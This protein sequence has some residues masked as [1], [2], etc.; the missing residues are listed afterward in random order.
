MKV[1]QIRASIVL[2]LFFS[3]IGSGIFVPNSSAQDAQIPDWIKNV[4]GWW[5]SGVISENEFVTGIEYLINN[6][7]ILLDFVPCND[8]IQSQYGDTKS[9]PDWIKNNASWWSDNLIGDTDFINGLQYL[10][11]YKIIKIDNKKILGK[12]PLEDIRFSPSWQVDKNFLVFVQSSFFEVY[13]VYGNCVMDGSEQVWKS[14]SL[15][16]NPN[17]LD[18]YN[19]VAVWN[20][21]QKTVVVYPYFTYAAYSKPGFYTYYSGQCDDCTTTKFTPSTPLYTSSGIGHQA[22]TLLGYTSITD[23]D[24]DRN[25]SIL[26]QFD[27]V[28]MLH[29][30]YV[31]RTMFDAITNHPN[32]I[33]LYPNALYAEIEVNYIDETITLIRGHNYPEPEITNGF[34]WEFDNTHPYEFDSECQRMNIYK[35][36]NGWMTTCYPE[37]VFLKKSQQLFDLLKTIKD[38]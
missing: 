18:M 30:E 10:I 8:K 7:I 6:N 35:I 11:E 14:L 12:V 13:G 25:P 24:I 2:I 19:E 5:A 32:V 31:T 4:A 3:L 26:Q 23:A 17:K 16:L 1:F 21:P 38:L 27:K 37:N 28:I 22:L 29:N 33:Y 36:K 20:D 9:V 15:G 34:D